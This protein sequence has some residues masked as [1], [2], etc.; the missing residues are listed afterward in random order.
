MALPNLTQ[1]P[2]LDLPNTSVK[3][4]FANSIISA[5]DI[6]LVS[7]RCRA[8]ADRD[9]IGL[10]L[11]RIADTFGTV[12]GL[13]EGEMQD[14]LGASTGPIQNIALLYGTDSLIRNIRS[15][16]TPPFDD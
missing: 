4:P 13:S 11:F 3:T 6:L 5:D 15:N 1:V 7:R 2:H 8:A 14:L 9:A 12:E 16:W 10:C